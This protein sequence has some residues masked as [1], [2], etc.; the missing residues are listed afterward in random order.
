[1]NYEN[2]IETFD[3]LVKSFPELFEKLT[4]SDRLNFSTL[5]KSTIERVF[6]KKDPIHG[7]YLISNKS[8]NPLYV[9]RSRNMAV[10][11]GVDHRAIQK[12]QANLTYKIAKEKNITPVEARSFMYENFFVRMIEIDNEYARTLFE[13]YV[14]M[15]LQTP[16][17]SFRES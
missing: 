3:D 2:Y 11:I 9:G 17:N 8:D 10:R 15:K 5:T 12:A 16:Y 6:N 14:A 4:G 7:I 1:M 13:V